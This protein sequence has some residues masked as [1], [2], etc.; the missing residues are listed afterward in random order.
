MAYE[1]RTRPIGKQ[2][3][4]S[5]LLTREDEEILGLAVT[6]QGPLFIGDVAV[7]TGIVF[8]DGTTQTSAGV[9]LPDNIDCGSF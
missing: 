1:G 2:T 8:P 4:I 3:Y 7:T 6:D 5:S 9:A